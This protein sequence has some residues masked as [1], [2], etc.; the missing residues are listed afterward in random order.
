MASPQNSVFGRKKHEAAWILYL[1][2][3]YTYCDTVSM[4]SY[5]VNFHTQ[6]ISSQSEERTMFFTREKKKKRISPIRIAN[7]IF[8]CVREMIRPIKSQ[9]DVWVSR[10][11]SCLLHVQASIQQENLYVEAIKQSFTRRKV[12]SET[13]WKLKWNSFVYFTVDTAGKSTAEG[14]NRRSKLA[15]ARMDILPFTCACSCAYVR[16]RIMSILYILY[17]RYCTFFS[18]IPFLIRKNTWSLSSL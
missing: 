5:V 13:S 7:D 15:R 3:L 11:N 10:K 2:L 6:M 12:K 1:L 8:P 9:S 14:K 18:L 17:C 16:V 4:K